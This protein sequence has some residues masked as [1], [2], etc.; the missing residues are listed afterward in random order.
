MTVPLVQVHPPVVLVTLDMEIMMVSAPN[1][2][3]EHTN[4]ALLV[5]LVKLERIL[6]LDKPVAHVEKL[7]EAN[8]LIISLSLWNWM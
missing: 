6:T 8:L 2:L 7:F 1:V 3:L 4:Q 5:P